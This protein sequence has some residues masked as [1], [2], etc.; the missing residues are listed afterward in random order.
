MSCP[1]CRHPCKEIL[2]NRELGR[3]FG[4]SYNNFSMNL[5]LTLNFIREFSRLLVRRAG[6]IT[7]GMAAIACRFP[8]FLPKGVL[9]LIGIGLPDG[10]G[11]QASSATGRWNANDLEDVLVRVASSG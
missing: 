2:L 4:T 10:E 7:H 6:G 5:D 9:P 3:R 8:F 1:A 11:R